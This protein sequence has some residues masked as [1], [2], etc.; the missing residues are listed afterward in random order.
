MKVVLVR[1]T[2]AVIKH[3]GQKQLGEERAYFTHSE[4]NSS[5]LKAARAYRG[6][7]PRDRS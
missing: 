6:Q 1:S 5:L 2:I 7:E 4:H 3:H